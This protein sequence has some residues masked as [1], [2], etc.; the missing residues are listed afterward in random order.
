VL[1]VSSHAGKSADQIASQ[2]DTPPSPA[3]LAW[4]EKAAPLPAFRIWPLGLYKFLAPLAR[5]NPYTDAVEMVEVLEETSF[6]ATLKRLLFD[7]D[8]RSALRKRQAAYRAEVETLPKAA[9]LFETY[10]A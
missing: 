10:L 3:T 2:L 7:D 9:D 6:V 4:L 5:N 1:G 8:A